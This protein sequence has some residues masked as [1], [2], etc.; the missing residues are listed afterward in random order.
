MSGASHALL[1][2]CAVSSLIYT[3]AIGLEPNPPHWPANVGVF[4]AASQ[5][6]A[7]TFINAAFSQNGGDCNNV[8]AY[9][10]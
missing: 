6:L 7:K 5:D 2:L 3:H 8:S 4:D 9:D 1:F 10:R